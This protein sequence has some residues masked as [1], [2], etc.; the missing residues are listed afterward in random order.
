MRVDRVSHL[1]SGYTRRDGTHELVVDAVR[2][3]EDDACQFARGLPCLRLLHVRARGAPG[4]YPADGGQRTGRV[5]RRPFSSGGIA[6]AYAVAVRRPRWLL[7]VIGCICCSP[8]NSIGCSDLSA[9]R[10][11]AMRCADDWQRT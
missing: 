11:S 6:V 5:S 9:H 4:R 8:A 1:A 3:L 2:V 7:A 10:S